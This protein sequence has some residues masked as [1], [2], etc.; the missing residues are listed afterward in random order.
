MPLGGELVGEGGDEDV[1]GDDEVARLEQEVSQREGAGGK[2][3]LQCRV[4]ERS[5]HFVCGFG[6]FKTAKKFFLKFLSLKLM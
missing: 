1:G 6:R 2:V 3:Y 4:F 5:V